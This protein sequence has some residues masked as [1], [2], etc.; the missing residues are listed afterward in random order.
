VSLPWLLLLLPR[1]HY[2]Q[3]LVAAAKAAAA[4]G[5]LLWPGSPAALH[6]LLHALIADAQH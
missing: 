2:Q 5:L 4:A 6:C 3:Q 1:Y